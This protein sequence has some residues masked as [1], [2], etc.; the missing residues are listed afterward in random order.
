MLQRRGL[1]LLQIKCCKANHTADM[2]LSHKSFFLSRVNLLKNGVL[3]LT[4]V[5]SQ[6]IYGV[7]NDS[8]SRQQL[9]PQ[10]TLIS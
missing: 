1:H 2:L 10:I 5:L 4:C 8:Q 7:S 6:S 3:T 9:F